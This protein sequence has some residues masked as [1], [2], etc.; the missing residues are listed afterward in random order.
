MEKELSAAL[1]AVVGVILGGIIQWL[2]ARYVVRSEAERLHRQLSIEFNHQMFSD[3]QV[4][5]R[6]T[7]AELLAA[8][9]PEVVGGEIDKARFVPLVLKAQLMLNRGIPEHAKVNSLINQLAL[10]VNGWRGSPDTATVLR[11]HGDLLDA[12][13]GAMYVPGKLAANNS[14][15]GRRP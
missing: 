5:F 10:E 9:D 13:M 8:S 3:W 6:E 7:M 1:M 2:A 4:R 12:A 14:L 11:V 15:Q